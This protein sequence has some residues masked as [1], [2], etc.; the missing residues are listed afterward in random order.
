MELTQ[1]VHFP[2]THSKGPPVYKQLLELY[3]SLC[4]QIY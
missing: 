3:N 2:Q 1:G 4:V